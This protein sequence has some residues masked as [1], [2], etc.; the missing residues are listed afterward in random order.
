MTPSA[1][2]VVQLILAVAAVA[3][4]VWS[5]LAAQSPAVVAPV[6]EGQP[7]TTSILYDPALVALA[8]VL[9]GVAGVLAVLG[10][11]NLRRTRT[12]SHTP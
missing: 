4:C 9:A 8:L 1:R 7:S 3:G 2:A 10:V 5:W 6:A 12:T 11:A